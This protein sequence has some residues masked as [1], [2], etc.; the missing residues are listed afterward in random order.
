[1]KHKE[2]QCCVNIRKNTF[3]IITKIVDY[4]GE[5]TLSICNYWLEELF[6][7]KH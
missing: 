2:R 6:M 3:N 7:K 1:M 5:K 4:F